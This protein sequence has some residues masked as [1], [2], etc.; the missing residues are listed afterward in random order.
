VSRAARAG[1]A[2]RPIR[3][4]VVEFERDA[5]AAAAKRAGTDLSNWMRPILNRAARASA[6]AATT[7]P[8]EAA[9]MTSTEIKLSAR[10]F[11]GDDDCLPTEEQ[12]A[13]AIYV[14]IEAYDL[15]A[16]LRFDV[17]RRNQRQIVEIAYGGPRHQAS[18]YDDDAQYKRVTDRSEP[19]GEARVTYYRRATGGR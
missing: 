9:K 12:V 7:Q 4:R 13:M 6:R 16:G 1:T 8:K 2:A 5:W 18:E 11:E 15:P 14:K 17:P 19:A 3:V 10:P